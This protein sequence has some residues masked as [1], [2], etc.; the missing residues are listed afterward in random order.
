M[1]KKKNEKAQDP[2][3]AFQQVQQG[4]GGDPL[5]G[6]G[7][8]IKN[9]W[10][11]IVASGFVP[12]AAPLFE[13]QGV[14]KELSPN[15]SGAKGKAKGKAEKV[16]SPT[17]AAP[18][19]T[20]Q[21]P[22]DQLINS[23]AQSYLTQ[24]DQLQSLVS[25]AAAP[26]LQ[27]QAAQGAA[28]LLGG[29]PAAGALQGLAASA[30]PIP[31]AGQ[32]AKDQQAQGNAYAAGALGVAGAMPALGQAETQSLAAAPYQQLLTELVNEATY[33][34]SNPQYGASAL[35]LT[36]Q[37]TPSWL[38][39]VMRN[40]GVPVGSATSTVNNLLTSPNQAATG[41]QGGSTNVNTKGSTAGGG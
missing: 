14:T 4:Q 26:Q 15:D 7:D 36:N 32:V 2:V 27:A 38:Q 29:S 31:M 39:T 19:A 16:P 18:Q 10:K 25:G 21:S 20:Q 41:G 9:H 5:S 17:T 6:V 34:A 13:A 23:L 40:L 11:E 35:G 3:A 28:G 8:F 33:R 30:P 22:F 24:A 12:G 37:N 1:A